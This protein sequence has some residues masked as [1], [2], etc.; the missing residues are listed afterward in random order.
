MRW[1]SF[2]SAVEGSLVLVRQGVARKAL[3][4]DH[5][6]MVEDGLLHEGV[7]GF[8]TLTARCADLAVRGEPAGMTSTILACLSPCFRRLSQGPRAAAKGCH[9]VAVRWP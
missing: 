9:P 5:V 4:D 6:R 3:S 2:P 1:R 8:D 7:E